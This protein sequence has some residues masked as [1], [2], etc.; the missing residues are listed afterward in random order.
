[1][2]EQDRPA[3]TPNEAE[4]GAPAPGPAVPPQ[5]AAPQAPPDEALPDEDEDEGED[6]GVEAA[7]PER[8]FTAAEVREAL[9]GLAAEHEDRRLRLLAEYDNYRRRVLREKEQ[10]SEEALHGFARD[11][12]QVLDSFEKALAARGT[13]PEALIAGV[14]LTDRQLRAALARHGVAEVEPTGQAFDPRFHE[15][16]MRAPSAE[17]APGTVLQ[18]LEK[19]YTLNGKLLRAARVVVAAAPEEVQG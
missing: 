2:S 16:L 7:E 15:A 1:V 19:G 14:E 4:D 9:G 13:D 6:E 18:V 8:L 10:W 11:L 17:H 3:E 12:L 5:G